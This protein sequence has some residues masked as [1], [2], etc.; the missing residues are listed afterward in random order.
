MFAIAPAAIGCGAAIASMYRMDAPLLGARSVTVEQQPMLTV[1][2][3][4]RS[5]L[6][7]A[8][9]TPARSTFGDSVP[10]WVR[11]DESHAARI[12][13]PLAGRVSRVFV[14]LGQWVTKASIEGPLRRAR[15]ARIER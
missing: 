6:E 15:C 7:L 2:V 3:P 8:K 11:I 13:S 10:A 9:A 12:G 14:E 5:A 4:Q 1:E